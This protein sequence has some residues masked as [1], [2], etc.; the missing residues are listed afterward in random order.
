MKAHI[1][2]Q[3][4]VPDTHEKITAWLAPV[5]NNVS[6]HDGEAQYEAD[7]KNVTLPQRL[8]LA[9]WWYNA[10][11]GNGGHGQLYD[12]STGI[13]YEDAIR[14]FEALGMPHMAE[15]IRESVRR[16]GG[17]MEKDWAKR[18]ERLSAMD[19]IDYDDLDDQWAEAQPATEQAMLD[20]IQSHTD[21][22][23]RPMTYA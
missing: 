3:A 17:I 7:L 1:D 16:A 14:G 6:I 8:M 11:V 2:S 10:E 5:I 13:V 19:I 15:V 20:Y 22:F 23:R 18:Q 21:D 4:H 9:V 12:N